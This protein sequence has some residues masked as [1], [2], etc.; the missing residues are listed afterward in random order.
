M[1]S[2]SAVCS[3]LSTMSSS[4]VASCRP[5][6]ESIALARRPP[7]VQQVDDVVGDRG[8]PRA[9][10]RRARSRARARSGQSASRSRSRTVARTTVRPDCSKS[11]STPTSPDVCSRAMA[12]TVTAPG[13]AAGAGSPSFHRRFTR[14][15]RVAAPGRRCWRAME[16]AQQH[17]DTIRVGAL[18]IH[19]SRGAR[20]RRRAA[21]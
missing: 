3:A 18:E 10:S 4:A 2:M 12:R 15:S 11:S 9:R 7:V 16:A 21:R 1:P 19:P 17:E 6:S 14:R 5:S 20:P 8:R 13:G